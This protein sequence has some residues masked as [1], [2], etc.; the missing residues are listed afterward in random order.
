MHGNTPHPVIASRWVAHGPVRYHY[1]VAGDDESGIPL[2]LVHGLGVSSAYWRRIQPLLATG[3]RVYAPD[4]PGFGRTTRPPRP[5]A[6]DALARALGEWLDALDVAGPVHLVGHSM[7]GQVVATFARA[8]PARVSGLVL[9][10]STI[11]AQGAKAPRQTLG[12]LRDGLSESPSLLPVVLRDYLRAGPRRILRTDLL[13]DDAD[14]VAI[15]AQL[16]AVPL[17]IRGGRDRVVPLRDTQRLL[18]AAPGARCIEI[19]GAAHAVHW[20]R[21]QAV[22]DAVTAFLASRD[23]ATAQR[24][25]PPSLTSPSVTAGSRDRDAPSERANGG[26]DTTGARRGQMMFAS[27]KDGGWISGKETAVAHR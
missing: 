17:I 14:T 20:S 11:G 10:A 24:P 26:R 12:L 25:S 18:R 13:A 2:V 9:L 19:P 5:L 7:G 15:A 16:A 4:L 21:P 8:H 3:R 1:R 6:I 22:A 23:A 27:S